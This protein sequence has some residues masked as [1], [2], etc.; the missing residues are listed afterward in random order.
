MKPEPTR[1]GPVDFDNYAGDYDAALNRGL[2]VSGET[3]IYFARERIAWL[4]KCLKRFDIHP[5]SVLDFGCGS[6]AS[7]RFFLDLLG[8]QSVI[9]ADRSDRFLQVARDREAGDRVRF[10]RF[11]EYQTA[12]AID[13]VFCNGVFHHIAP[14]QRAEAIAYIHRTLAP[15]GLFAFWEN[16][17][18]NPGTRYVMSRVAFDRDAK[19]LSVLSARRMLR[20]GGFEVLR[21]DFLFIFPRILRWLRRLE[22][23]VCRLPIGAQYQLLCRKMSR[24]D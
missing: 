4:A 6:G 15:T 23:T 20:E 8:A 9:G 21:T 19:T 16:N 22:P 7:T 2:S 17:P 10:V 1:D 14:I 12:G 24:E 5:R 18:W 11:D 3:K 13:L